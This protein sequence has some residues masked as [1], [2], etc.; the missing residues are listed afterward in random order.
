ME[1]FKNFFMRNLQNFRLLQEIFENFGFFVKFL[2]LYEF[3]E[4]VVFIGISENFEEFRTFRFLLRN[5]KNFFFMG[6]FVSFSKKELQK[7]NFF[8][9]FEKFYFFFVKEF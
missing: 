7:F 5:F 1:I 8:G 6:N 4:H 2:V 9:K 3:F